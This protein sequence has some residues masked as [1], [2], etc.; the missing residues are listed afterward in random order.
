MPHQQL[1]E[2]LIPGYGA[3]E[4]LWPGSPGWIEPGA[5]AGQ[6]P[7]SRVFMALEMDFVY[8][9]RLTLLVV[10][11]LNYVSMF[12]FLEGEAISFC[13]GEDLFIIFGGW[14]IS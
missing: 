10:Y 11:M 12:Y 4:R 13:W 8:V 7:R 1:M 2:K 9:W 5:V 6:A 3:G 14:C